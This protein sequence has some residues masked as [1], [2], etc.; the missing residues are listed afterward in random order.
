MRTEPLTVDG[1]AGPVVVDVNLLTGRRTL[2]VEGV[3]IE[4]R[5]GRYELATAT[6]E[7]VPARLRT[8][9]LDLYPTLEVNGQSY[10]T[11]PQAPVIVNVL[12][13][14]PLLL[15]VFGGLLGAVFAV[16][17]LVANHSLARAEM[18]NSA[19]VALMGGVVVACVAGWLVVAAVFA[20]VTS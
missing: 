5:R 7:S 12:R 8:K 6:G 15:V 14:L 13:L 1:L 18:S 19:K 20:A 2:S 11:G 3:P 4:G 17:G 16:V 9:F 10:R